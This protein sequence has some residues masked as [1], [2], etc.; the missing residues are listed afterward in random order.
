MIDIEMSTNT[1]KLPSR[2]NID[3]KYLV[4]NLLCSSFSQL[5]LGTKGFGYKGS[6]IF[7]ALPNNHV[8]AGD[9]E[10]VIKIIGW[11]I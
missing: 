8:V 11:V 3:S 6:K 9:F 1:E 2:A 4:L 7:R 10:H 5:C